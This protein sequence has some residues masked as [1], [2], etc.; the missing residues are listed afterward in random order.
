MSEDSTGEAESSQ[1]QPDGWS[2]EILEAFKQI[3]QSNEAF[4]EAAQ[5][6]FE[7]A[8]ETRERLQRMMSPPQV[9]PVARLDTP[10]I[11]VA[12]NP[13]I[14]PMGELVKLSA[15]LLDEQQQMRTEAAARDRASIKLNR[16]ILGVAVAT[17]VA[18]VLVP[19][20]IL[21]LSN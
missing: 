20:L 1:D 21:W 14:S 10:K 18:S 5:R 8:R 13:L 11:H 9:M 6:P 3:K 17:L 15:S 12:K 19:F 2:P 7:Q 16:S 4:R